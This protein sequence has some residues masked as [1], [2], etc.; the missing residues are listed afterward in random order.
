MKKLIGKAVADLVPRSESHKPKYAL[1]ALLCGLLLLCCSCSSFN[2]DWRALDGVA[3]ADRNCGRWDGHWQSKTNFHR[4]T[5]RCIIKKADPEFKSGVDRR[6]A[7]QTYEARFRA[8]Y[9]RIIPFEY[10]IPIQ[11]TTNA[12]GGRAFTGSADLGTAAGG[13]YTY[14]GTIAEDVF[15][16]TYDSKYDRGT[17]HMTQKPNTDQ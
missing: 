3:A 12:D 10:V 6:L 2:R 9:R 11:I 13:V 7:P 1:S 16:S 14:K 4:G 5:L 8:T 15:T 17:F